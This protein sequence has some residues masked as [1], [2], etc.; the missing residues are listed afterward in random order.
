MFSKVNKADK[1][2]NFK[3][4]LTAT[5]IFIVILVIFYLLDCYLPLPEGYNGY[6]HWNYEG[7]PALNYFFGSCGGLLSNYMAMGKI[8]D[9]GGT[10]IYRHFTVMLLHGG[11]LHLI[12]NIAGL[13]FIGNYTEKKFGWWLTCI[14]FVL[15]AFTESFI[16][17][18][19]YVAMFPD[20][21]AFIEGQISLGA[22]GGIFGLIGASLSVLFFDIKSF[23]KIDKPTLIVSAVYGIVTTYVVGWGWTT[24]CHNVAMILGLAF[25]TAIILPFFLL[26]KGKFAKSDNDGSE[27]RRFSREEIIEVMKDRDVNGI[28]GE[29]V[30][31]FFSADKTRRCII[32]KSDNGFFSYSF[33]K[34][35]LYDE[36]EMR[37]LE[38]DALPAYWQPYGAGPRPVINDMDVLMRELKAEP[39]YKNYFE[40]E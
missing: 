16:T 31:V 12:A 7:S 8:V 35:E 3:K 39:E 15:V 29:R 14:L 13:Y 33:E 6:T 36:E 40:N 17:D 28:D 22:S 10:Q 32:T 25:G 2:F 26:K 5:N 1:K 19:L 18:P 20:K 27:N 4:L 37:W 34:L 21:A 24:V 11:L 38:K 9:P 30:G 23:K